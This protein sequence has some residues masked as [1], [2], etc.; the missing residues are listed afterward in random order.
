MTGS[1][2]A[3]WLSGVA[4]LMLVLSGCGFTPLYGETATAGLSRVVVETPDTRLG[5]RLRER[6]ED[7]LL[8]DRTLAPEWRLNV[9]LEPSRRPLGRRIDDT[10]ARYEMTLVGQW[11]LTPLP[12]GKARTGSETVTVTYAVS[13][14]PYAAISAQ[15]DAEERAAEAL[16]Q[17]IRLAL[18][19]AVGPSAPAYP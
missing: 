16:A 18:L 6:L 4:A 2:R 7:A 15:E 19:H 13:D 1:L 9:T 17:R 11:T 10:A 14:Q 8:Y 5:Y 3:L 12:G